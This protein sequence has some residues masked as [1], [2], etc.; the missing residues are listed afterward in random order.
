M[1]TAAGARLA[2]EPS[3]HPAQARPVR[4]EQSQ[5]SATSPQILR[6]V[7]DPATYTIR[8]NRVW[9]DTGFHILAF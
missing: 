2:G 9:C 6:A 4:S 3:A 7:P 8:T 1:P 5:D